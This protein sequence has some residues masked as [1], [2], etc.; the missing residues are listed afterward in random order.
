MTDQKIT[1]VVELTNAEGISEEQT[2]D[3]V[4]AD[5]D[6]Q[7]E[8]QEWLNDASAEDIAEWVIAGLK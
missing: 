5:R 1:Q 7:D 6:N 4:N 8:H 3:F 2:K